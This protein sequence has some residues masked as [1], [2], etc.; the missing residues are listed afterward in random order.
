MLNLS[1][2]RTSWTQLKTSNEKRTTTI[3]ASLSPS[4]FAKSSSRKLT[5]SW[6]IKFSL[7]RL[8]HLAAIKMMTQKVNSRRGGTNDLKNGSSLRGSV[9]ITTTQNRHSSSL[10]WFVRTFSDLI[11]RSKW[12]RQIS[13]GVYL[14]RW[15]RLSSQL[16]WRKEWNRAWSLLCQMLSVRIAK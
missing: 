16:K 1:E 5:T 7:P 15:R 6:S 14:H 9:A 3:L 4:I 2:L 10:R 11:W 8:K 12:Q 13:N